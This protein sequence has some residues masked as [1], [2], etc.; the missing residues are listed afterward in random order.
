MPAITEELTN[1]S[2]SARLRALTRFGAEGVRTEL[3]PQSDGKFVFHAAAKSAEFFDHLR[4]HYRETRRTNVEIECE[5]RLVLA[6]N[7]VFD[8]GSAT[9]KNVSPS[10]AL[11]SGLK[12]SKGALPVQFFKIMLVLKGSDY[13]GIGIE[14]T[15][16]RFVAEMAGVG[17]KFDEI[18]V[19]V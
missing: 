2:A 7:S 4:A 14:A 19:T 13:D 18:F 15:P 10:G 11:L 6:D 1:T 8:I 16:V 12:L 5:L 3:A 9:V 17:V